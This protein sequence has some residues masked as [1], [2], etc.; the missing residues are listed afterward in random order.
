MIR[1]DVSRGTRKFSQN[2]DHFAWTNKYAQM[3]GRDFF[4][5]DAPQGVRVGLVMIFMID[6][7]GD[8][9]DFWEDNPAL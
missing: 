6:F 9:Y 8:F 5:E 4:G 1:K 2:S 7:Y 3:R